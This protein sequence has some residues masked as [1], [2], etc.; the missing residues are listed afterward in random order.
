MIWWE[1]LFWDFFLPITNISHS[2]LINES[3][4]LQLGSSLFGVA[5]AWL[6]CY[7]IGVEH[8]TR[9]IDLIFEFG[10]KRLTQFHRWDSFAVSP[11]IFRP[12][13][14]GSSSGDCTIVK[15]YFKTGLFSPDV[16]PV[17]LW[18]TEVWV[19]RRDAVVALAEHDFHWTFKSH[20]IMRGIFIGPESDHWECLSVTHSLTDSLNPV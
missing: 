14:V 12:L 6:T 18:G 9:T 17:V 10:E 7:T 8:C 16:E 11:F 20:H 5:G 2:S 19:K 1:N 13:E 15:T 4:D 3:F